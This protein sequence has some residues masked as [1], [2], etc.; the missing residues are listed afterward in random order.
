[1]GKKLTFKVHR[2]GEKGLVNPRWREVEAENIDCPLCHGKLVVCFTPE[3]GLYGY[4]QRCDK[5]FIGE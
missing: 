1:M 5:Y 3:K 2:E 4:C